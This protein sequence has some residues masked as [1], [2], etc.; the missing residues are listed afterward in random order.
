MSVIDTTNVIESS[1][2]MKAKCKKNMV[3]DNYY[4]ENLQHKVNNEWL[5]RFNVVDIEEE[6]TKQTFYTTEK[7]VY[8]PIEVVIQ[9]VKTDKGTTF[10]DDW[11]KLV[12]RDYKH[13]IFRGKRYRFS[14]DFEKNPTYTEE[15]KEQ[16]SS[17]WIGFNQ[18][19][20]DP[21]NS[22][23]VR[24]CNSNIV[25]AG[26]PNLSYD[27]ITEYH[28]E[29]CVLETDFKSINVYMN[30]TVN[31]NQAEIYAIMQYNYFTQN[32]RV[33]DRYIIGDVDTERADLNICFKVKAIQ[34]FD[35]TA[36]FSVGNDLSLSDTSLVIIGLDRDLIGDKDDL[37]N[38]VTSQPTLYK[39]GDTPIPPTPEED[40]KIEIDTT[41][42]EVI[43]LNEVGTYKCILYNQDKSQSYQADFELETELSG[44]KNPDTYYQVNKKDSQNFEITNKRPFLSSPLALTFSCLAPNNKKYSL[45]MKVRLGGNY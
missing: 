41:C 38:R 22:I 27:N 17:I 9:S 37:I 14:L 11:K 42:E 40:Y 36:T 21:T 15:E 34:R 19:A 18:E 16:K 13:P 44:A 5:Y 29:P 25:F 26:S 3:G 28:K 45:Q 31:I 30:N 6:N 8:T 33:N 10:A 20:V 12:F 43:L 4:I 24:R 39:V 32:I 1:M 23:I 35:N 7:P 2:F